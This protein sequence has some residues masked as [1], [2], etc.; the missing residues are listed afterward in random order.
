[1]LQ[2]NWE[3]TTDVESDGSR[4]TFM[5]MGMELKLNFNFHFNFYFNFKVIYL[6]LLNPNVQLKT[7]SMVI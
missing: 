6:L 2:F 7:T 3:S 5:V 1:M 4:A